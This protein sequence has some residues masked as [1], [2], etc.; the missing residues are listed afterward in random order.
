MVT[1]YPIKLFSTQAAWEEWLEKHHQ[2]VEGVWLRFYKK[3][4]GVSSL[5][6]DQA[7]EVAL[8]YGWIDSQV[9][10]YDDVSYLQKFTPR[11]SKSI[12]SKVNTQHIE[13]LLK[14]GKMKP[15]GLAQVEA[16]KLDGRWTAAYDSPTDM[17][18][19]DEFLTELKKDKKAE[20]FFIT[21]NRTNTYAI[22][23]RL[24]TAKKPETKTKRIREIIEMLH[25][26]KKLH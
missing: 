13:R 14:E 16:A 23:W 5:V 1:E 3:N 21:L 9:K 22:A 2:D 17:Q 4:S 20:A 12:W 26:E 8:C 18:M 15:A 25:E 6:Y 7:L 19:P 24:Q 10:K 11:R